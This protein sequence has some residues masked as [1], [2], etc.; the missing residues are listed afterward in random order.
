MVKKKPI[1]IL[2]SYYHKGNNISFKSYLIYQ[3]KVVRKGR[4][5]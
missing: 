3:K 2:V 1:D 5:I 4:L